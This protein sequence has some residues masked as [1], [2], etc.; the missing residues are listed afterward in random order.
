[1]L[2]LNYS[3][4]N[5]LSFTIKHIFY[6]SNRVTFGLHVSSH[7]LLILSNT[8]PFNIHLNYDLGCHDACKLIRLT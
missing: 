3:T 8:I 4:I 1:M 7:P 2:A 6:N 5:P